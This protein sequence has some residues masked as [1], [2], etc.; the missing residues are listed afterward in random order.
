M[1]NFLNEENIELPFSIIPWIYEQEMDEKFNMSL[2]LLKN[3]VN[4]NFEENFKNRLKF[5]GGFNQSIPKIEELILKKHLKNPG[6]CSMQIKDKSELMGEIK[7]IYELSYIHYVWGK[8]N[9]LRGSFPDYCCGISSRN[10]FLSLLS[11]GYPNATHFYNRKYDHAYV[12]LPFLIEKEALTGFII[13]DPTSDQLFRNKNIAPRNYIFVS[14]GDDWE[15]KTDWEYR[16]NLFP[17]P[18]DNS[19][20]S[21]LNTLR[22]NPNPSIYESNDI[23]EYFKK[24]FKNPIKLSKL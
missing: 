20:Y 19:V 2:K 4:I 9:N 23:E 14:F 3:G 21:N 6:F 7:E 15:Y 10:I 11:L 24:V 1:H 13:V 12:G 16:A 8:E 22:N 5:N 18:K 17:E